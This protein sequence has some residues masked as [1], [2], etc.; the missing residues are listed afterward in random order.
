MTEQEKEE[1]LQRVK[2]TLTDEPLTVREISVIAGIHNPQKVAWAVHVLYTRKEANKVVID[3]W[4][5][6]GKRNLYVDF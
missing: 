3:T 6:L 1:I 5:G 2:Q 4:S